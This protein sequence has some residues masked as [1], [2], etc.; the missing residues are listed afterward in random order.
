MAK[1]TILFF[2]IV[3]RRME[4]RI[5]PAER[6]FAKLLADESGAPLAVLC[7][8]KRPSTYQKPV[9]IYQDAPIFTRWKLGS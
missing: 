3:N 5:Y 2:A 7:C 8:S 1:N 9:A 4:R 6:W